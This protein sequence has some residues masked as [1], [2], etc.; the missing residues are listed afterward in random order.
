MTTQRTSA[1]PPESPF[2]HIAR[3]LTAGTVV[4]LVALPL[5]LG[6]ALASDAPL[7][8][9]LLAG[10]VGGLVVGALSGSRTSVSGPAAG[11]TAIV[12]A[13]IASLGSF[14][15]FLLAVMLA[16]ALQIALGLL[17]AGSVAAF[18]PSSVI[19]GLLAAIGVILILKQIPHVLGHDP[20]PVGEM[21]FEQP[22]NQNTFSELLA[23]A[24][25]VHPGAALVGLLSL[26]LLLFWNEIPGA[27]A[28]KVPPPLAVV[29]LGLGLNQLL[30]GGFRIGSDHLVQV[31]LIKGLASAKELMAFPAWAEAAN[32]GVVAAAV[33]IAVVA[34]LETLL[35]LEAVD[36]LDPANRH[37]PPNRELVAQGCGNLVCG[38]IGALPVTSVIVRSSV[39]IDAGNKTRLSTLF[40][41]V[42]LLGSVLFVPFLLNQIPL[43]AL[44]AVLIVTGLKLANPR[45]AKQMWE[46]GMPQ[47]LPFAT[48]V[49]AI[50]V[51]DL[52][53]GIVIGLGVSVAFILRSN[54]RRPIRQIVEKH[55][56]GDVLRIQLANQV[57]FLN[58]ASLQRCLDDVPNGGRVVVDASHTDYMDPDV[59]DLLEDFHLREAISRD[60]QLSMV[61][62]RH[63]YAHLDSGPQLIDYST[64]ELQSSLTPDKVLDLLR[65]GNERFRQ[66][67]QLQRDLLE[68]A[69]AK[70][71]AKEAPLAVV[72]SCIESRTPIEHIL[73]L[74]IGEAFVVRVAGNVARSKVVASMEFGC[75][76]AGAKLLVVM[77]HSRCGVLHS[78]LAS[79]EP[80]ADAELRS[81][82]WEELVEDIRHSASEAIRGPGD[83][84]L[85]EDDLIARA[86]VLR[87]M[88]RIQERSAAIRRRIDDGAVAL[89][90][91]L[92]EA[93]TGR[94][95]FFAGSAGESEAARSV[96]PWGLLAVP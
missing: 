91:A 75:I 80:H 52:L 1:R 27:K 70:Q 86:H 94:V 37:S 82:S 54:Y 87:T 21:A 50:V 61:G 51:T 74:G 15:A 17:R 31:P 5:C 11:L 89:V 38:L 93:E 40:H 60:I 77:G 13:Q 56:A 62:F 59:V 45:Q 76:Q 78:A 46:E 84:A 85:S 26:A 64:R 25:D 79:A 28:S 44:A 69:R 47:F 92:Y 18:F 49:L 19:K 10:I 73:D 83:E 12:A 90:G 71:E 35:N 33:T 43:S 22:D 32:P 36:N 7:L 72:L 14:E 57:S 68:Q 6:V 65:E 23:A 96:S 24:V 8:S 4:F 30:G 63:R 42:L 88:R 29:A 48:T 58:K 67:N 2:S 81:E 20:D 95:Q 9:G 16:G 39:N 34:T 3:D 55:L 41:G 53:K 66:G